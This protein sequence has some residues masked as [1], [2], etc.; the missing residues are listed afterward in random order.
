[1][2]TETFRLLCAGDTLAVQ[3]VASGRYLTVSPD[4]GGLA[5]TATTLDAATR[6]RARV[7]SSGVDAAVAAA[8]A[9]DVAV[10]VVG[11]AP[12]INGK[13][14]EDRVDIRLPAGQARLVRAVLAANPRTV[15]V[16]ESSYPIAITW[17]TSTS[18]RSCGP[19]T[20]ARR[21]D[22]RSPTCCSATTRRLAG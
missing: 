21:P 19:R 13:E 7:L 17:R 8:R 4:T 18:R 9:A 14:A 10:V 15:L 1:M 16:V 2:V 22:G 11:N 20:A 6:F 12:C 3:N 5:A